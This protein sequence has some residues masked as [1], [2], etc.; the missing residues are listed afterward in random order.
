MNSTLQS[1]PPWA[2]CAW[3]PVLWQLGDN[4]RLQ[5]HHVGTHVTHSGDTINRLAGQTVWAAESDDGQAGLAW[6]WIQLSRGIVA[7]ADPL[8]V[9]TNLRLLSPEGEVLTSSESARH[10]NELVH[11]LPWQSEVERAV[12]RA[13]A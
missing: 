2:L 11:G 4:P 13:S 6:D 10:L 12:G 7:M 1:C 5:L 9:V 8:A 3:P